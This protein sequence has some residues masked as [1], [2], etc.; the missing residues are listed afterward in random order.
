MTELLLKLIYFDSKFDL[1]KKNSIQLEG[2]FDV[3]VD[4]HSN[5]VPALRSIKLSDGQISSI[6]ILRSN[7]EF[8]SFVSFFGDSGNKGYLKNILVLTDL[9]SEIEALGCYSLS[10]DLKSDIP[11]YLEECGV[12]LSK[13]SEVEFKKIN[14]YSFTQFN[15]AP[16]DIF[17]RLSEHKYIKVVNKSDMYSNEI[18]E[19]YQKRSVKYLYVK[20]EDFSTYLKDLGS[21]LS[22]LIEEN[23]INQSARFVLEKASLDVVYKTLKTVGITDEAV[24]LTNRVMN[25]VLS[26]VKSDSNLW[27]VLKK[28]VLEVEHA[29]E[30]AVA[31]SYLCS[32]MLEHLKW[33]SL[34]T[35][36]KMVISSFFHD[37]TLSGGMSFVRDLDGDLYKSLNSE[38]KEEFLSHPQSTVVALREIKSLPPNVENIILEHHER[39][40]GVGFPRKLTSFNITPLTCVFIIAEEF[41]Y[42]INRTNLGRKSAEVILDEMRSTYFEGNFKK[43]FIAIETVIRERG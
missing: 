2:D 26:S 42:R 10:K 12:T 33:D 18:I 30:H 15:N 29:A 16:V 17:I 21:N 9:Q 5:I 20:A 37:L 14:I 22:F 23:L 19:R 38:E 34:G 36:S 1:L 6:F 13:G 27:K 32:S 8:D 31:I 4:S 28:N 11:Q 24:E 25:S 39:P 41:W 35:L 43:P 7:I 40:G 3:E